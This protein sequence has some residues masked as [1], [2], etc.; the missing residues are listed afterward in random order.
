VAELHF[1]FDP[2]CPFAWMTSKWVRA[3]DREAP[4][5]VEWRFISLRLLNANVDYASHF[6][7][8]YER[9]HTAGLE[10]LRVAAAARQLHG[11]AVVG[12][13][14]EA[15]GS[16]LFEGAPGRQR[17]LHADPRGFVS[18]ILAAVGLDTELAD[19]VAATDFDPTILSE[20]N[21]ALGLTGRDV[22]TPILHFDPP[23][24]AALFG[25]VISRLPSPDESVALWDHVVALSRFA[26]FA[27]LKR[28]LR[29]TPQLRGLGIEPGEI[30]EQEDWQQGHRRQSTPRNSR[31]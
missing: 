12:P 28:S 15:V 27:E 30:G 16:E 22:G 8:G 7:A 19:A 4:L 1:Y 2:I 23:A 6:P 10:L 14:Y 24:G 9:S 11:P 5:D 21:E 31:S 20:T 3:V 26:G 18:A 25:P 17:E 13:F 29:E